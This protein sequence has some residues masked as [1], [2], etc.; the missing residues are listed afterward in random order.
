MARRTETRNTR[1]NYVVLGDGITEQYYLKHLKELNGYKYVLRPSLFTGITIE[2]AENLI[3]EYVSGGCTQIIYITDYDTIVSQRKKE[4]F[5]KIKRKYKNQEQVIICE[6]MPGIEFWFLLHFLKTSR[7]FRTCNEVMTE[8]ISHIPE[9]SKKKEYLENKIWTKM[10]C[11]ENRMETAM[12][13]SKDILK[14]KEKGDKGELF[15][16]SKIHQAIEYFEAQKRN[17]KSRR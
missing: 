1:K 17:K 4:K 10:L 2:S 16:Y 5:E 9:Y 11:S 7:E 14:E 6:S 8:L 3:D 12:V 15:P 13:N